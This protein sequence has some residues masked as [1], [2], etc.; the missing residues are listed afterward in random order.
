MTQ[1][2]SPSRRGTVALLIFGAFLGGLTVGRWQRPP[3]LTSL[4][5][6]GAAL[7]AAIVAAPI[8]EVWDLVHEKFAGT[9]S[10]EKLAQGVLRGLIGGIG[11][12]YSAYANREETSQFADDLDGSFT[13]IGVEIGMRRGVITVIAPLKGSPAERAGVRAR[14]IIVSI[15]GT[16]VTVET[17]LTD[18]VA[19]IRGQ[20]GTTVTLKVLREA[21]KGPLDLAV[22]RERITLES[23][24][25]RVD[26]GIGILELS[27]FHE[28]TPRKVRSIVRDFLAR[29]V[30]GVVIDVRNNPG[31]I[32]Q[33]AVEIAGH[34]VK[35]GALV[36]R[37]VPRDPAE[38]VERRAKGPG[39][40]QNLPVVVVMNEG[41]ASA[42]EIL[43]GALRDLRQ[44]PLVGARS[45]GK[46]TV[47]ELIDLSDGSSVR[48][49]I[50]KWVTASGKE[51][52][53]QGL[54]P[55]IA[56]ED[57]DDTDAQDLVLERAM[58]ELSAQLASPSPT[59]Q[60]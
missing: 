14:D 38:A 12:P 16:E 26:R 27:A 52:T 48:I 25:G 30:R 32:L 56:I 53:E 7:P 17:S 8:R 59:E 55:D 18:V 34:F 9:V 51:L 57:P 24:T 3:T 20:E 4:S 21:A 33:A 47:Q 60:S 11:D 45:F 28:D 36:V 58:K 2:S 23:A 49:T 6:G 46:G 41:S 29:G 13:G 37:E 5:P 1:S 43:A 10:D 15:D 39:D 50:A 22:K 40:L 35:D 42:S 19:K 44:V 54:A 31:G